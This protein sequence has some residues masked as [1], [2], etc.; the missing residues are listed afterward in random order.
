MLH[1]QP[2]IIYVIIIPLLIK[3]SERFDLPVAQKIITPLSYYLFEPQ[4]QIAY[5]YGMRNI[6]N[7]VI[8]GEQ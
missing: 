8:K 6:E 5:N 2:Q 4:Y 3:S 7:N 1:E